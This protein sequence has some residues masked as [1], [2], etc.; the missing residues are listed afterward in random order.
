MVHGRPTTKA[1]HFTGMPCF[2]AWCTVALLQICCGH[3]D[4]VLSVC[5]WGQVSWLL[6]RTSTQ[7]LGLSAGAAQR[8]QAEDAQAQACTFAPTQQRPRSVGSPRR[9]KHRRGR[10]HEQLPLQR[11]VRLTRSHVAEAGAYLLHY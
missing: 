9:L 5:G 4:L 8:M 3:S 6:M 1:S 11:Q 7:Q 2:L 10:L